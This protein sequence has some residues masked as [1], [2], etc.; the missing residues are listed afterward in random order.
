MRTTV[1]AELALQLPD[2][3]E[4]LR[5]H[6]HVERGRRLV[7]DEH[8]RFEDERHRDHHA[9]P[10]PARELVRVA[11]DERLRVGNLDRRE[12]VDRTAPR[13]GTRHV[14]VGAECLLDLPADLVERVQRRERVLED[15]RNPPPAHRAEPVVGKP[16]EVDAV[17]QNL[18]PELRVRKP[19][20]AHHRQRRDA[21]ARARFPDHAERQAAIDRQRDVVDRPHH[22]VPRPKGDLEVADLEER[23]HL[24]SA[25]AG[26]G[27]RTECRRRGSR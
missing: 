22:A 14:H 8:V 2:E 1:G 12:R 19:G 11:V 25:R 4:D 17:E 20:Q 26:R 6:V 5:L 16:E 13:D 18:A 23:S 15:H 7:G 9:L 27:T 24:N 21:L 10:H 3:T